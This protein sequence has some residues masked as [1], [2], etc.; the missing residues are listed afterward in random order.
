MPA[1][2]PLRQTFAPGIYKLSRL[3]LSQNILAAAAQAWHLL[4]HAGRLE[5]V[6]YWE[7]DVRRY[8]G[9]EEVAQVDHDELGPVRVVLHAHLCSIMTVL[10][11]YYDINM[12]VIWQYNSQQYNDRIMTA[13]WQ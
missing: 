8:G 6:E 3:F 13:L 9:A 10:W 7:E 4:V 1:G 5:V 2:A 11:Q 12:T